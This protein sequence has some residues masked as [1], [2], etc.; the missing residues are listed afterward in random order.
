MKI[1]LSKRTEVDGQILEPGT[2]EV[3]NELA[4]KILNLN[5]KQSKIKKHGSNNRNYKRN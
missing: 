4:R 3:T 2:Y 5:V 1:T